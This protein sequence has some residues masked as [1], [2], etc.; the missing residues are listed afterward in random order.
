MIIDVHY[1]LI[2]IS[3]HPDSPVIE[4]N[5]PEPLRVA[6]IMDLEIDLD[7]LK[8]KASEMWSDSKGK[9]LIKTMDEAGIDYTIVCNVDN[10]ENELNTLDVT[11]YINKMIA[12]I[13][14][15]YPDKIMALAGVD[16]R[17]PESL[18]MLKQCFEEFGM[19]GLK[20]HADNGYDPSGPESYELLEYIEKKNGILLTHTGPLAPHGRSKFTEPILL[21]DI[22]VDFPNLK[23]IAAHMGQINWRPWGALAALYPNL[24][25]DLAMWAPLAF[26]RFDLFCRELRDIIDYVGIEKILFGSDGPIYDIVLPVNDVIEKI[27]SLPNKAPNGIKFTEDEINAILGGNAAKLLGI[28]AKTQEILT[29]Y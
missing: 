18:Q 9:K 22:L 2:P 19:K 5:M 3:I 10:A 26:G 14:K 25:G 7:T 21:A 8:K 23:I 6:K 24:Y 11:Q 1:H 12:K 20:Y 28:S 13:A 29:N 17:R 16:P 15:K 27:R 4:E